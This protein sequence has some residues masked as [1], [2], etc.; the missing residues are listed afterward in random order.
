MDELRK[1]RKK[2]REELKII[3]M[4]IGVL[5]GSNA[6]EKTREKYYA[7]AKVIR[8]ELS[9]TYYMEYKAR[10]SFEKGFCENYERKAGKSPKEVFG[11]EYENVIEEAFKEAFGEDTNDGLSEN[12][13]E[14]FKEN[15]RLAFK[16]IIKS[17]LNMGLE[18]KEI[19]DIIKFSEEE[20]GKLKKD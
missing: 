7:K 9:S 16:E 15:L 14:E 4:I 17:A 6:D 3:T 2:L 1:H 18:A 5:E 8:D 11:E 10:K 13:K 20:I 12:F 19:V